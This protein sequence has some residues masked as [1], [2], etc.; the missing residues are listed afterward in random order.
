MQSPANS[1]CKEALLRQLTV[2]PDKH[3]KWGL[4]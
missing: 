1:M 4:P 2:H 3:S